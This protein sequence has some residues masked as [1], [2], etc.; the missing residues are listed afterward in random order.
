MTIEFRCPSCG[1]LLRTSDDKAGARAKCPECRAAVH[2]PD[3]IEDDPHAFDLDEYDDE[4]DDS[5]DPFAGMFGGGGASQS[6]PTVRVGHPQQPQMKSCP[7]CGAEIRAAA[8]K[9]RY[10]GEMLGSVDRP[11]RRGGVDE[12]H[13]KVQGPAI[14]LLIVFGICL[15]LLVFGI[16]F[17]L[18]DRQAIG[19]GANLP[20]AVVLVAYVIQGIVN[21]II[22]VAAVK[23]KNLESYGWSMTGSILAMIPF[24]SPCCLLG[25]P[26]GI[27]ALVVLNDPIV[28]QGFER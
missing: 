19:P 7:M 27:W 11:V 23:M 10:C 1:K 2:V 26:F 13:R 9:C 8:V 24:L 15:G 22:L 18:I 21:V 4:P 14:A 6:A 28:R 16:V 5:D 12:A 25:L 17:M 3:S 20:F